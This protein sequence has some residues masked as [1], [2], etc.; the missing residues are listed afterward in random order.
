MNTMKVCK[1]VRLTKKDEKGNFVNNR[2][3]RITIRNKAVV[4]DESVKETEGNYET[5]GLLYIVDEAK[6]KERNKIV[7]AESE[8]NVNLEEEEQTGA[9]L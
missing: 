9:K 3:G 8:G 5:T 4:S 7:E 2:E 6:T 1:L